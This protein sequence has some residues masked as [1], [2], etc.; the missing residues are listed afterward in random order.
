MTLGACLT[1]PVRAEQQGTSTLHASTLF[2][3]YISLP[4]LLLS[5]LSTTLLQLCLLCAL[6]MSTIRWPALLLLLLLVVWVT[7]LLQ[8]SPTSCCRAE[9]AL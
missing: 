7:R 5:H 4:S 6:S 8:P 1:A 9:F 3:L 2:D